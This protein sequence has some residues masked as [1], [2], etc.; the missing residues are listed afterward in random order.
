MKYGYGVTPV[1]DEFHRTQT[2]KTSSG[3][4][5]KMKSM[6]YSSS[7]AS[8]S[9]S[10]LSSGSVEVC[11]HKPKSILNASIKCS[12][13]SKT[14]VAHCFDDYQFPNGERKL[15]INCEAGEWSL[16]RLEWSDKL[17]CERKTNSNYFYYSK[18]NNFNSNEIE[19]IYE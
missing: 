10:S 7:S 11:T 16:E 12:L 14:C 18:Q 2:Y 6:I 15:K 9:S 5:D 1:Q 3:L 13:V 4:Y 17:A 19:R 8:S